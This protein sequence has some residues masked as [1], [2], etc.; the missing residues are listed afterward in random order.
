MDD[1]KYFTLQTGEQLADLAA[2][3]YAGKE[4]LMLLEFS[5]EKMVEEADVDVKFEGDE[6]RAYAD[7]IPY[8]CMSAPP[9]KLALK[10]GKHVLPLFGAEAAAAAAILAEAQ[11][12][13]EPNTSDD[14]GLEQ[15]DQH[16][17][18]CD[19]DGNDALDPS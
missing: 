19:D 1:P 4:D 3:A 10:D 12:D 9:K 14:D 6:P 15:F 11:I 17:Y 7:F 2:K 18:D 13:S 5:V 8:A 16:T